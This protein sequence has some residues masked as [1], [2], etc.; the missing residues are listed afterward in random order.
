MPLPRIQSAFL[1]WVDT[2]TLKKI[3]QTFVDG[4]KVPSETIIS[5]NGTVQPYKASKNELLVMEQQGDRNWR[6]VQIH[7]FDVNSNVRLYPSDKIEYQDTVYKIMQ[8]NDYSQNGFIEYIAIED[9][10]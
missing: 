6:W 1:G 5:F 9:Y 10:T 3:T 8:L 7:C 2:V 4:E